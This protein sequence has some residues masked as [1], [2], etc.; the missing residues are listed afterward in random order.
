MTTG[1]EDIACENPWTNTMPPPSY[2]S[3]LT[4]PA[5]PDAYREGHHVSGFPGGYF[6]IKSV[7]TGKVLDVARG[8]SVDGTDLILYDNKER[9]LVE[10]MRAPETD[11]Q[12]FFLDVEGHLCSLVNGLPI[13]VEGNKLVVRHHRPVT[14]PFPNEF[15]HPLPRFSYDAWNRA[16]RVKYMHDPSYPVP[17]THPSNQWKER[18]YV[19]ASVPLRALRTVSQAAA[20]I[21]GTASSF[22]TT[23]SLGRLAGTAAAAQVRSGDFDLREDEVI[24]EE[25]APEDE[26]DDSP[27]PHRNVRILNL[28]VGW[29]EK[30]GNTDAGHRRKWEVISLLPNRITTRPQTRG[31]VSS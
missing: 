6:L 25:R 1:T 27:L 7:A 18:D 4:V 5:G 16:I 29:V 23:G 3:T 31:E 21:F 11:N 22:F 15:S 24:E 9:S 19:M 28:P 8:E 14:L 13:D 10:G 20:E 2:S 26:I 12:V 17:S 30:E